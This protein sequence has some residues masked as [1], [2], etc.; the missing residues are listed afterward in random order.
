MKLERLENLKKI[1]VKRVLIEKVL[2]ELDKKYFYSKFELEIGLAIA[3][4]IVFGNTELHRELESK[5]LNWLDFLDNNYNLIEEVKNGEY[6]ED[7][8]GV[9]EELERGALAKAEYNKTIAAFLDEL[10]R[11]LDSEKLNEFLDVVSNKKE[12]Q[13]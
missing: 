9:F 10:G 1:S 6:A 4:L 8:R 7:Y 5:E 11:D 12:E 2:G 3:M 13:K